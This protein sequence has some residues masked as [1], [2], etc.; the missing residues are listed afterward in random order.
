MTHKHLEDYFHSIVKQTVK[1]P[2]TMFLNL[3]MFFSSQLEKLNSLLTKPT[4]FVDNSVVEKHEDGYWGF[5]M[6]TP[7]W[8]D[9]NG[10]TV[11]TIHTA[12]IEP[13]SGTWMEVLD[14][15]LDEMGKHYGYDIKE[16]VYYSVNFPLN[17]VDPYTG[18]PFA[19]YG[20][21]LNDEVLQ[22]LLLSFPEVYEVSKP[23]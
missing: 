22:Q 4:T 5:E 9:I 10:E 19:G 21:C 16:Q 8:K 2:Q 1:E 3:S 20:R 14:R 6:Y 11:E 15:I 13:H 17:D 18:V 23:L 12:F 7:E